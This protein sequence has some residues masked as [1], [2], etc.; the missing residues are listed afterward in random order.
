MRV[1]GDL[2]IGIEGQ[3]WPKNAISSDLVEIGL[4]YECNQCY[5]QAKFIVSLKTHHQFVHN[6]FL[7][8]RFYRKVT[9]ISLFP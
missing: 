6:I 7:D 5:H 4:K 9:F 2:L 1:L 3:K 8:W